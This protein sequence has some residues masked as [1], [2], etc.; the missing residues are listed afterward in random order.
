MRK[1]VVENGVEAWAFGLSQYVQ[2]AVRNVESYLA[3]R[4]QKL[5]KKA[6]TPIRTSHRPELDVSEELDSAEVSY[7]KSLIGILRWMVELGHA[8]MCLKV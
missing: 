7:Y 6:E 3:E 5:P 8:D 2:S 1:V 4:G